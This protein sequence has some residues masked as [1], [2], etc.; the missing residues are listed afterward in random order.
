MLNIT[1][2]CNIEHCIEIFRLLQK[3]KFIAK[4][5]KEN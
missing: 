1:E 5:N 3:Q 2:F 4:L